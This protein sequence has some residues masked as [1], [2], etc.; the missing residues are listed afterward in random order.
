VDGL[1]SVQFN[2]AQVSAVGLPT[3]GSQQQRPHPAMDAAEKLLGMS[4]SDLRTA[5]QSGQSLA[6]IAS[7]KGISQ[8]ALTAAMATAIQAANPSVSADQATKVATAIA[9]RTPPAGGQQPATG[10]ASGHHHHHHHAAAAATDA[11][12]QALG[13]SADDLAAALQSGQTLADIATSQGVSQS[14]LTSAISSAL[15]TADSS[16]SADQAAAVATQMVTGTSGSQD[17][18]WVGTGQT[19]PNTYSVTA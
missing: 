13:M 4:A 8:D 9:T 19:A 10:A 18:R 12:A 7:S 1:S 11:A 3:I 5:M 14:S 6:S 16:L 2:S 15:Q 17:Q